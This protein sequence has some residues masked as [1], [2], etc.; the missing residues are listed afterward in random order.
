ME[1]NRRMG[2]AL[3]FPVLAVL[4][5]VGY[6]G[7]LGVLFMVLDHYLLKEWAVVVLGLALVVGVPG[8]AA[9]VQRRVD[10]G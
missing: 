4:I 7:G 8:V 10:R 1:S 9:L 3:L 2:M 5:I 6:A